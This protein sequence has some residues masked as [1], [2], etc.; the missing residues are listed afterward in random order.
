MNKHYEIVVGE[1]NSR[2]YSA[3]FEEFNARPN[4][5]AAS[6]NWSAFAFTSLWALYR[7]MYLWFALSTAVFYLIPLRQGSRIVP[8][9][10]FLYLVLSIA[11]GAYGNWLYY[12]SAR[13]KIAHALVSLG[14]EEKQLEYLRKSGGVHRWVIWV[15]GLLIALSVLGLVAAVLLPLVQGQ[16]ASTIL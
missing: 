12:F 4:H 11:F 6:W 7:R 13:K 1:R 9:G 5:L 8:L 14:D 10:A 2:Y 15:F 16:S 3:K